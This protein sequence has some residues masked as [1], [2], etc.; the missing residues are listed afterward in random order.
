[1]ETKKLKGGVIVGLLADLNTSCCS[2]S[3]RRRSTEKKKKG[4]EASSPKV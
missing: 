1:M 4:E 2:L 3:I